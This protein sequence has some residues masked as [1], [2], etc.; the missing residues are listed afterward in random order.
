M[1]TTYMAKPGDVKRKWYVVDAQGQTL[2]RLASEVAAILR[3]KTKPQYTPHIDVGDN[4]IIVN[5]EKIHLTGKKLSQKYY[6]RH[7][8]YPG[9]LRSTRADDMRREKPEKMLEIAIKGM[10]P[11]N[12]LGREQGKKLFV[13][14]GPEHNHQA[15]QPE[16]LDS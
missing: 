2:G 10:L 8:G 9:G 11:K 13:Y 1:R 5:A 3:G 14:E 16:K 15:Q 12:T 6:H 7:S 4:V